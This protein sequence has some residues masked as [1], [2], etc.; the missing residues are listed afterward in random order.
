MDRRIWIVFVTVFVDLIGFGIII[1]LN[2]YLA[3]HFGATPLEVGLLMSVYSAMQFLVSPIWGGLS[4]RFGRRPIIL[5]SLFGAALAHTAFAFAPHFWALVVARTFAGIFGANIST[6]MAYVADITDEKNRSK[7]MGLVGAA[8]GIGFVLGPFLGGVMAKVGVYLGSSPPLGESFPAL[9]AALICLLNFAAA[10]KYL[11]ESLP[12]EKR[13]QSERKAR[14]KRIWDSLQTPV[15][16]P[17]VFSAGLNTMAMAT[18]EASL[19]LYVQDAFGWGLATASFGFAYIGII[20]A[21]TQGGLVRRMMPIWGER[22]LMFIGLALSALGFAGL[23]LGQGLYSMALAVTVLGLGSGL[24]LPSL[25]GSISLKSSQSTQ[26]HNMGVAQSL[27]SLARI[28]GPPLGG[29]AYQQLSMVAPFWLSVGF[30]A[31]AAALLLRVRTEIPQS[32]LARS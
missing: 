15:L 2:P 16:G 6:A 7:G 29:L 18:M 24:T 1:P 13:N 9:I 26:G 27:S 32:G 22:R 4:D 17:L 11:P 12:L 14:F 19:F 21:I 5:M 23:G 31:V 28:A 8:F 3:E 30:I 10:L 20:L 25:N